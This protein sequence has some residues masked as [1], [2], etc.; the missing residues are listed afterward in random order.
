MLISVDRQKVLLHSL[1]AYGTESSY[2]SKANLWR[3]SQK[4]S[5]AFLNLSDETWYEQEKRA[6]TFFDR[7]FSGR[8]DEAAR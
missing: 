8:P 4:R 1:V 7:A 5:T 2:P 6:L 3:Y